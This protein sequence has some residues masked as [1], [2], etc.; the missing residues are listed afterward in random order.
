VRRRAAAAADG[1]GKDDSLCKRFPLRLQ[2]E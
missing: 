1:E 2:R